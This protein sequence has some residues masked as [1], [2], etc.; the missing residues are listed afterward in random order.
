LFDKAKLPIKG[1]LLIGNLVDAKTADGRHQA[2]VVHFLF[3]VGG[4]NPAAERLSTWRVPV[5]GHR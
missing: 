4:G 1:G 2:R 5:I 3:S